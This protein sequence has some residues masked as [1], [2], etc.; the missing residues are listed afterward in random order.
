[1]AAAATPVVFVHGLWLHADSWGNW[2]ELFKESGYAPQAPGWPGDSETIEET[3]NH[4]ERVAPYGI[5]DVVHH[6]AKLSD[7]LDAKPILVGHSFGGLIVQRLLGD[8]V[9][10]AAV[11]ID[12]APIKG[13]L[14]LPPSALKVAS[15]ALRSPGNRKRAVALTREQF[16]YGFGNALAEQESDELF[17][18]WA[19]PSPGRPLFEAAFA[20]FTPHSPAKVNSNNSMRG[21]LLVTAGGRDHTVPASISHSTVKQYR[22]SRAITE[23]KEFPDRGHSLAIDSRWREVADAV[24]DWLKRQSL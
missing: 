19:I 10:A 7:A 1:M 24:L 8:G 23:L 18:R 14:N 16:R 3:R 4:P 9:A 5:D 21:P 22:K 20:N 12:P 13:I 11:A 2:V 15:I 6:Y 17:E